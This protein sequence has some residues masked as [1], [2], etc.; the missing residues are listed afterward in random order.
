MGADI[1]DGMTRNMEL[2]GNKGGPHNQE[3][4]QKRRQSSFWPNKRQ[5]ILGTRDP[6]VDC[7][8]R[9]V[10]PVDVRI[11]CIFYICFTSSLNMLSF[12]NNQILCVSTVSAVQ[13]GTGGRSKSLATLH[14]RSSKNPQNVERKVQGVARCIRNCATTNLVGGWMRA[15][16]PT[17]S[18]SQ[19]R[20]GTEQEQR[21]SC[22]PCFAS[23]FLCSK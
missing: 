9:Q 5:T 14:H 22:L 10:E 7:G 2:V 13:S 1:V 15:T 12:R 8:Y 19:S 16:L 17:S 21:C 11:K 20:R 23:G 3:R 4:N 18:P 6:D